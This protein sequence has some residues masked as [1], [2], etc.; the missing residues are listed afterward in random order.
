[1]VSLTS[2]LV[3][4]ALYTQSSSI[5]PETSY[6]KLVDFWY[7]IMIGWNFAIILVVV[8]IEKLLLT[9]NKVQSFYPSNTENILQVNRPTKSKDYPIKK[10]YKLNFYSKF[11]FPI[12][13]CILEALN[14]TL[15]F[16][17]DD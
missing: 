16:M 5:I 11:I 1:M 7:I 2:L 12:L 6:L 17:F 13:L 9:K 3:L 15:F 4:A 14:I 8:Y 10:A